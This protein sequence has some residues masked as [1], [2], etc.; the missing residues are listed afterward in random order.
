MIEKRAK[1]ALR[2]RTVPKNIENNTLHVSTYL[3]L[4]HV[5]QQ[6]SIRIQVW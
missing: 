1:G 3:L 6:V 2:A 5:E 4:L